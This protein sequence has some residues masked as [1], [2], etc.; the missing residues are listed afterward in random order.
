M[1]EAAHAKLEGFKD[2]KHNWDSY[3]GLPIKLEIIKAAHEFLDNMP[4]DFVF[5]YVQP[6]GDGTVGFEWDT[7]N[8]RLE[9]EIETP[10]TVGFVKLDNMGGND[11]DGTYP[12]VDLARTLEL[13]RWVLAGE[14]E[15]SQ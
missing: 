13:I 11:D 3:G 1:Y 14:T 8:G 5:P 6:T 15:S 12:I 7:G 2:L 9:L 4:A 10:E